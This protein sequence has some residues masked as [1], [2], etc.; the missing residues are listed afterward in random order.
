MNFLRHISKRK[1]SLVSGLQSLSR[2]KL[3]NSVVS[4]ISVRTPQ[5]IVQKNNSVRNFVPSSR[6]SSNDITKRLQSLFPKA[7]SPSSA[8]IH[9]DL[10]DSGVSKKR[11][12]FRKRRS[13]HHEQLTDNGYFNVMAFATA[14]EYD[15]EKLLNA[16][17]TQDLYEP[18]RFFNS[19]DSS[20]N[21]PD[22]LYAT[23]KYQV[24]NEPRELYFFREGTVILWNFSDMESSNILSFL[25][26]YEQVTFFYR[27]FHHT[28]F[29]FR[30]LFLG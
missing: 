14:E 4:R 30:L 8:L 10:H 23:A 7:A 29:N 13:E 27:L 19:D 16:L 26:N 6:N 2:K 11:I 20:E 17:K 5:N 28:C 21:Q 1:L 24:G 3:Q 15:L 9:R 18:K 25:K 22:V 12:G